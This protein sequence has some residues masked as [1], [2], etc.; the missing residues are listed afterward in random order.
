MQKI[1]REVKKELFFKK[2]TFLNYPPHIHE[3]IELVY[4]KKGGGNAFCNGKKYTLNQNTVFLVFPNQVHHYSECETGEY[5]VMI[6]KPA[7]L[8]GYSNIFKESTPVC[9]LHHF[10]NGEDDNISYLIELA[11]EEL[12]RDGHSTIISSYLTAIFG[13]IFKYYQFEKNN[14]NCDAVS[15]ILRYCALHYK[16]NISIQS[17]SKHTQLCRSSVSHTFNNRLKLSFRDYINS[18]RLTD[19]THMLKN[20]NL[21]ITEISYLCG[22]STVRTFNRA[23]SKQYGMTPSEYKKAR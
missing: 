23:F 18:L 1:F 9:A 4:V 10:K 20:E 3:D 15:K 19:A 14:V 2:R 5:D 11:L 17:V 21:S 22:F 13:K 8:L 6:I 7:V 12:N 16:E